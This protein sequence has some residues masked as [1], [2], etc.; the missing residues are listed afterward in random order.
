MAIWDRDTLGL[1]LSKS[2][3]FEYSD[4]LRTFNVAGGIRRLR[5]FDVLNPYIVKLQ[6][7]FNKS[8]FIAFETFF[9][10]DLN[11]GDQI[12][13]MELLTGIGFKPQQCLF[14]DGYSFTMAGTQARVTAIILVKR[15]LDLVVLP[16]L[17]EFYDIIDA[18]F[19]SNPAPDII[20]ARFSSNPAPDIVDGGSSGDFL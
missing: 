20:D 10:E 3:N 5:E 12:F 1:P 18:R 15:D 13:E 7:N 11:Q 2:Y 19:S 17:G 6:F 14:A 4:R 16:D 8:Q 9:K